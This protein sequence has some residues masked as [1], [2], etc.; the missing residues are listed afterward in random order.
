MGFLECRIQQL[1]KVMCI[2]YGHALIII[3]APLRFV[4]K[5]RDKMNVHIFQKF[6]SYS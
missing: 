2:N 1:E 3:T 4:V 6:H 5:L